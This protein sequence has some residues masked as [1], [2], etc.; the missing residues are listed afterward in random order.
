MQEEINQGQRIKAKKEEKGLQAKKIVKGIEE[1]N[2]KDPDLMIK[3]ETRGKK[4][5]G[6]EGGK[7]I[8]KSRKRDK[9]NVKDMKKKNVLEKKNR[10][11]KESQRNRDK[12]KKNSVYRT[13]RER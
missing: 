5:K 12:E 9:S 7:K 3:N 2:E 11:R 10:Q 8:V 1:E 4:S 13:S 6:R